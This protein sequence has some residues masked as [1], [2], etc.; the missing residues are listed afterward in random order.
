M[1][2]PALIGG[3]LVLGLSACEDKN[4]KITLGREAVGE[5][6]LSFDTLADTEWLFL[7][8]NPDKT[9]VPDPSTRLKFVSEGGAMKAKYNVGSVADMYTYDC[10]RKESELVCKEK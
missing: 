1:W 6:S 9:E 2:K 5:C 7:K 10:E 3:S 8:A 4:P